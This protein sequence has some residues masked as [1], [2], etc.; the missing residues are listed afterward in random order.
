MVA[1]GLVVV[2]LDL[3][4][5]EV[6]KAEVVADKGIDMVRDKDK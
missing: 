3:V 5:V 4:E 2:V 6:D 1:P